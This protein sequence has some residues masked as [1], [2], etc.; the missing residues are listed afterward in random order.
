M[1]PAPAITFLRELVEQIGQG[2]GGL[3]RQIA[4]LAEM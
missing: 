1:I 4:Y 2:S 3:I